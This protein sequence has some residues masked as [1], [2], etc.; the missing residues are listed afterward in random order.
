MSAIPNVRFVIP[1]EFT[2]E[3]SPVSVKPFNRRVRL[4]RMESLNRRVRLRRIKSVISV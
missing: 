3:E 4:R 1:K 2:T